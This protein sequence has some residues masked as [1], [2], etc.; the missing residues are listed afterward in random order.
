[1]FFCAIEII[2][3]THW[4]IF[5]LGSFAHGTAETLCASSNSVESSWS[6]KLNRSGRVVISF[7]TCLSWLGLEVQGDTY[8]GGA[9]RPIY[10]YKILIIIPIKSIVNNHVFKFTDLSNIAWECYKYLLYFI[11]S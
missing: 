9:G 3:F 7:W 4:A 10:N 8:L 6:A 11:K 1:M 2:Q 5:W